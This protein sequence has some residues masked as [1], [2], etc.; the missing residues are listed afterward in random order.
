MDLRM[1]LEDN[2]VK[3]RFFD[4]DVG[5]ENLWAEPIGGDLYRIE[6]IPFFVYNISVGDVVRA[7]HEDDALVFSGLVDHSA[8]TTLRA[9]FELWEVGSTEAEE[10][11]DRLEA[12]GAVIETHPPR[13]VAID[14]PEPALVK[15][16][17]ELLSESGIR[18]D[19][20]DKSALI[21]S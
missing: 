1:T 19:W 15:Q 18:W 12:S 17:T 3:V 10:F 14:I 8:H 13:L 7:L 20:A 16:I 9:R 4:K 11:M 6:S 5:Y 21:E 2:L